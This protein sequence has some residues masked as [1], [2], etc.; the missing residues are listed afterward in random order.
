MA[1]ETVAEGV[2]K[3]YADYVSNIQYN[4]EI[5]IAKKGDCHMAIK[6]IEILN[7]LIFQRQWRIKNG[8]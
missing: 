1:K 3:I 7:V 5:D 4:N 8:A 6:T 2:K